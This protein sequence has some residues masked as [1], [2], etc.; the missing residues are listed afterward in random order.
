MS[1]QQALQNTHDMN[2]ASCVTDAHATS[3]Q[4]HTRM[5]RVTDAQV[6]TV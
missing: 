1:A 2:S 5:M 3:V 4:R 6:L